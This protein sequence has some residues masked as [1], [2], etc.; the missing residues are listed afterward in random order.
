MPQTVECSSKVWKIT[1]KCSLFQKKVLSLPEI[2]SR[3]HFIPA[4]AK[5]VKPRY[6]I[7]KSDLQ[8]QKANAG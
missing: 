5:F 1:P 3:L 6:K 8:K 4:N 2:R 7:Q